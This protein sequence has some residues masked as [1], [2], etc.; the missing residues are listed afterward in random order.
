MGCGINNNS[1]FGP[2]NAYIKHQGG[3]IVAIEGPNTIEKLIL[4]D[5]KYP[6]KQLLKGRVI[7][8]AGQVNY[9]MNHLGL[10][11]NATYLFI[12][13]RYN[14]KAVIA[15]DNYVRYS[16]YN[17]LSRVYTFAQSLNLTGTST[18]R[19]PQLYLSNPNATYSVTLDVLVGV[20]DDNYSFFPDN[21][22]NQ[23]LT[24]YELT[25]T[26]IQTHVIGHSFKIVDLAG[27]PIAFFML[28]S[29][30][31]LRKNG[32]ILIIDDSSIGRIYLDFVDTFNM[33]QAYSIINWLLEDPTHNTNDLIPLEDI[34]PPV[35]EFTYFV[36]LPGSTFSKPYNT[37]M[38]DIF[39]ATMSLTEYSGVITN[40]DILYHLV[41]S[42]TD[43]R[44]GLMAYTSS[45]ILI[46]GTYSAGI[47][48]S[49]TY[50][51]TFDVQ[52]A[53]TNKVGFDKVV[54]LNIQ[55]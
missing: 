50:S 35:I 9:L 3:D 38:G 32:T 8:K 20:V 53:A 47:S 26:Q 2:S 23:G 34:I 42:I 49:G 7:L 29:I 52:D 46:N 48:A 19:I 1:L 12:V 40:Q 13:A 4:S 41:S 16:Y 51:I 39:S 17:D 6:Y 21:L 30:N 5:I 44:D 45:Y 54:E 36:D 31:S 15:E 25:Y 22:D 33:N 28:N 14:A 11:D 24:I 10:G 27:L 18:K 55:N 43:A 37:T